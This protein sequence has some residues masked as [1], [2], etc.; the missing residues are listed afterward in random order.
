MSCR[1][2]RFEAGVV[3]SA[4]TRCND[5]AFL[6]RPNHNPDNPLLD[7]SCPANALDP[8]NDITPIPSIINIIG[9]SI[10]RALQNHPIPL[11]WYEANVH[12]EHDGFTPGDDAERADVPHFFRDAH[13]LI[14]REINRL[15]GREN[16]VYGERYRVEP[17][18][19]D[20]SAEQKLVYAMANAVK[21]GQVERVSESPFFST[22]RHLAY[23]DPLK[24]WY[25]DRTAWWRK[26]GPIR[27]NRSKDHT[28]WVTFEL[29][30]LPGWEKLT[31]HQR[32]TRFRHL[33]R[34]AE[35]MAADERAIEGRPVAGVPALRR[36]DPRDRP[37]DPQK[38]GRQPLCHASDPA[39][40]RRYRRD[41]REFRKAYRAA[42]IAYRAG[43]LGVEF[44][45]GSFRPPLVT[46][47][48]A[49]AL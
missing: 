35:K 22:F 16:H 25:T 26:G 24:F 21:D 6:F 42:S 7:A 49:S 13:S 28:K 15:L 38:S 48:S 37:H 46:M 20:E 8:S 14:A 41:W 17:C 45:D 39:V 30:P 33:I 10:G 19:D 40:R 27:G 47:Y 23:G 12:H 44:P 5:R 29:A 4:A 36:L 34:E 31:V 32:R 11:N 3:Y 18:L 1:I 9:A 2:R 43:D